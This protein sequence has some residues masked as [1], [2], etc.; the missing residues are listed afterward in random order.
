LP[1]R[2]RREKEKGE[3][4]GEEARL[5]SS[6]WHFDLFKKGGEKNQRGRERKKV[7]HVGQRLAEPFLS[8]EILSTREGKRKKKEGKEK[9]KNGGRPRQRYAGEGKKRG[10]E[11]KGEGELQVSTR[12]KEI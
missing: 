12:F 10:E 1:P 2:L 4:K 6:H 5:F 11:R 8:V 7:R 9:K 3:K